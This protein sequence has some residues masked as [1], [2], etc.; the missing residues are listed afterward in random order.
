MKYDC[1]EVPTYS[2]VCKSHLSTTCKG[3]IWESAPVWRV[4]DITMISLVLYPKSQGV[5]T[6]CT[7]SEASS[8][9]RTAYVSWLA[10]CAVAGCWKTILFGPC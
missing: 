4:D 7:V 5:Y 10:T 2:W 1:Q 9:G 3:K 6:V 8:T